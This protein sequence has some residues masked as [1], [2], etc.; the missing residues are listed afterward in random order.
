MK[1]G[2][3]VKVQWAHPWKG[4]CGEPG[5]MWNGTTKHALVMTVK[6]ASKRYG[7]LPG[8]GYGAYPA[9]PM[10]IDVAAFDGTTNEDVELK[11]VLEVV[12]ESR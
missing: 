11:H 10:M 2:D 12:S 3:L 4:S 9:S 5:K 8:N 1:V 7:G 6:P